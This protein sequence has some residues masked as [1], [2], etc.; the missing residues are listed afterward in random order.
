MAKDLAEEIEQIRA[1]KALQAKMA[2]ENSMNPTFTNS[3]NCNE[4]CCVKN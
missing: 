4:G 2:G 3:I 1:E